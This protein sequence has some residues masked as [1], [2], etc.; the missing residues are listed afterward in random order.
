MALGSHSEKSFKLSAN[1]I[2]PLA[3][4]HGACFATNMITVD[5]KPVGYMY[6]E[7]SDNDVD[8]GWRFFSGEETQVYVDNPQNTQMYDVN[9]I[10]NYDPDIIPLLNAPIGSAFE[11]REGSGEFVKVED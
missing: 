2:K 8:S 11:R 7:Q 9:T 10:A 4:G 6:R 3:E 1:E 5:G